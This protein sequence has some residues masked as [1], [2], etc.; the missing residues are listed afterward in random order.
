MCLNLKSVTFLAFILLD[1]RPKKNVVTL[2]QVQEACFM[3]LTS[4][5]AGD[6]GWKDV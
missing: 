2:V 6:S 5:N 3:C 4:V 1:F